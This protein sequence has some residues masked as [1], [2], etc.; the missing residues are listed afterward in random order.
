MDI[1]PADSLY[2]E[3]SLE[4]LR[5]ELRAE[6]PAAVTGEDLVAR[7]RANYSL[8]QSLPLTERMAL[9]HWKLERALT[10]R[11]LAATPEERPDAFRAAYARLYGTLPWLNLAGG[12]PEPWEDALAADLL[13]LLGAPPRRVL[14]LGSGRGGLARRLS[15]AGHQVRASDV[16]AERRPERIED[17]LEWTVLDAVRPDEAEPPESFDVVLSN[18]MIEHLHPDDLPLH[19]QAVRRL[20]RAG[21]RYIFTTPYADLGPADVSRIFGADRPLGMHLREYRVGELRRIVLA[22]GFARVTAGF[23]LPLRA[24]RLLGAGERMRGSALYRLH[25]EAIERGLRAFPAGALR[26]RLAR[27]ARLAL[28]REAPLIARRGA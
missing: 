5:D 15:A 11:L 1:G 28:F 20:L 25:L 4:A 16:A 17:G 21:G 7:Y 27:A 14:E 24:A 10:R 3:V 12:A 19:F 6:V 2:P 18:Q 8:P 9:E 26:R 13:S 23:R 22:A